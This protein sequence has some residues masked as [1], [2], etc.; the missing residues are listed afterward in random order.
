ME[1]VVIV[2]VNH[3]QTM[4]F[5]VQVADDVIAEVNHE[6]TVFLV[7]QVNYGHYLRRLSRPDDV[8]RSQRGLRHR[9]RS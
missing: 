9:P 5:L 7:T 1:Y 2:K 6:M 8:I 4:L 3:D